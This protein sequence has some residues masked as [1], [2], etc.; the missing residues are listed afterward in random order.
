[1]MSK[2]KIKALIFDIGGVLELEKISPSINGKKDFV[3]L[4]VHEYIAKKLKIS[5]DQWFDSIDSTYADSVEGKISEK[6]VIS[7]LSK[8]LKVKPKKLIKVVVKSYKKNF[9]RNKSLYKFAFNAK[10]E[11]YKIAILSDQWHLSKKSLVDDKLMKNFDAVVISSDVGI[12][13]PSQKIYKLVLKELKIKPNYA[14]FI[15]NQEWN[16]KAARKLG[17]NTIL[18]KN[19]KQVFEDL[20]KLGIKIGKQD[21]KKIKSKNS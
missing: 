13:K 18:Y 7:I 20:N 5:V 4:G 16:I 14:V 15:D 21:G 1:M 19:N 9:V 11:G 17:I 10:K 2:N 8:N 6:E 12:R 3:N